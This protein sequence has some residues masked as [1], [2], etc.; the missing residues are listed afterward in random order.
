MPAEHVTQV[1]FLQVI[2]NAHIPSCIL[3]HNIFYVFKGN[4]RWRKKD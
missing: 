4:H 2:H 1:G 3:I